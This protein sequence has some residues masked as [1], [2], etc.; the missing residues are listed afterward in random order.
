MSVMENNVNCDNE[1]ESLQHSVIEKDVNIHSGREVSQKSSLD[2]KVDHG[3]DITRM[4]GADLRSHFV[5]SG[6]EFS[7]KMKENF[8]CC[9]FIAPSKGT[10]NLDTVVQMMTHFSGYKMHRTVG[11]SK[12]ICHLYVK[13]EAE[14]IAIAVRD[15]FRS[16]HYH[17]E[18]VDDML[19]LWFA[20]EKGSGQA[21][22]PTIAWLTNAN[23]K[24]I[25]SESANIVLSKYGNP[26][27]RDIIDKTV[28]VSF[29][30]LA[31]AFGACIALGPWYYNNMLKDPNYHSIKIEL[32]YHTS[33]VMRMCNMTNV[34]R[35]FDYFVQNDPNVY[36]QKNVSSHFEKAKPDQPIKVKEIEPGKPAKVVLNSSYKRPNRMEQKN[37]NGG[38]IFKRNNGNTQ[39]THHKNMSQTSF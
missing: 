25:T 26:D 24:Y 11:C 15:M 10:E 21:E 39:F 23:G 8:K 19:R 36:S 22:C 34:A 32:T 13:Y 1:Q 6:L 7:S 33:K 12:Q 5:S 4:T 29:N 35:E 37:R 14:Y 31:E 27:I 38:R 9:V 16:K 30:S 28:K 18:I 20:F 17:A 2:K 3:K